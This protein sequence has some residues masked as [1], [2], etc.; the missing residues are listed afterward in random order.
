MSVRRAPDASSLRADLVLAVALAL[1]GCVMVALSAMT[2]LQFA[3]VPIWAPLLAAVLLPA[4]LVLRR[5][6]PLPVSI[7]QIVIYIVA[8]EAAVLELYASQVSLFMGFYS[9]G[10]WDAD[11]RR[12]FWSRLVIVIAMAVWLAS[13]AVRGFFDPET[14]ERGVSAFFAFLVIQ[15]V[16]NAAYFGAGWVF[17]DR[18][19]RSAV[20]REALDA[21]HAEIQAQQDR[22]AEQAVSLERLRIARELHDVVAHHVS[23]MGVQAG[24][25]RRVLDR[26][27]VKAADAL[28]HVEQSARDAI[29][30]LRSLVVTLRSEDDGTSA[31]PELAALPALIESARESG[32]RIELQSI[33]T[34]RPVTSMVGLTVYRIVQEAL[35][36]SRKHAGPVA[37]VDVRLRY[38]DDEIEVEVTDDGRGGAAG[39]HGA[40]AGLMGMRERVAALGGSLEVGPRSR[41]G[42]LV[43]ARVP[44][45]GP[46]RAD[47]ATLGF[48]DEASASAGEPAATAGVEAPASAAPA[49]APTSADAS[50]R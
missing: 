7:A 49:D 50:A 44:S 34:P 27:P 39:T 12:A 8:G 46:A 25:A 48:A 28:R 23:A 20:E 47:E 3:D 38:L 10:A 24:A 11:R 31:A 29:G 26:D 35:T 21:A 2:G 37:R 17:G 5:V 32:Q 18:A 9:I 13:S 15:I 43:R 22:L 40:G 36:N 16:I 42:W 41:G 4:P 45:P 6:H 14:G 33:G 19:W 1:I 30:E